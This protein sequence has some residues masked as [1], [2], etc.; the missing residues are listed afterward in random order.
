M[1]R[2]QRR[3]DIHRRDGAPD[4]N[5]SEPGA[6]LD[7]LDTTDEPGKPALLTEFH[8]QVKRLPDNQQTIFELRYYGGLSQAQVAQ[9]LVLHPKQVSRPWLA[10]TGRLAQWLKAI[11]EPL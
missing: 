8:E 9:V 1:G 7:I 10:A 3:H 11:H 4:Q 5:Q 6:A 2:R